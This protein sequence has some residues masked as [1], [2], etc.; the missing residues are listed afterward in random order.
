M[1][2]FAKDSG[3][4]SDRLNHIYRQNIYKDSD[5]VT[6]DDCKRIINRFADHE[7]MYIG[8]YER[9]RPTWYSNIFRKTTELPIVAEYT[10]KARI[11]AQARFGRSLCTYDEPTLR[12]LTPDNAPKHDTG[13]FLDHC[14]SEVERDGFVDMSQNYIPHKPLSVPLL[15]EVTLLVYLNG[16]FE[17]GELVFPDYDLT[18]KPEA[19]DLLMFP[20]GHQYRHWVTPVTSGTRYYFSAFFSTPKIRSLFNS[21]LFYSNSI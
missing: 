3:P 17:G 15:Y 19:G 8:G 13:Y 9:N 7:H 12:I 1:H 4:S 21:S 20:S 6:I 2:S 10:E 18:I 5:F 16:D 14:D 11:I